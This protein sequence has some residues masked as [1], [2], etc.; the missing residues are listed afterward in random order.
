MRFIALCSVAFLSA[1]TFAGAPATALAAAPATAPANAPAS[2]APP[3][4]YYAQPALHGDTL[5]FQSGGDLW[6]TTVPADGQQAH[7]QRLTSAPGLEARPMISPDGT[8]V[9]Y[10]GAFD[11]NTEVFTLPVSGGSPRRLTFHP[12][13]DIPVA[14]TPDGTQLLIRSDRQ[15]PQGNPEFFLVPAAGGTARR[16]PFGEGGLGSFNAQG[17]LAFNPHSNESWYWKGYRGGTAPDIWVTDKDFKNYRQVTKTDENE[18]FPMW[19]QGRIWFLSDTDGRMNLWSC[20]PD[21]SDRTQHTHAGAADFDL[22]WPSADSSGAPR[23]AFAQGADLWLYD[24]AKN[25]ARK[26]DITL[27]GDRLDD[28]VRLEPVAETM[29]E[30]ALSPDGKRLAVVSRGEVLVGPVGKPKVGV[31][32]AWMQLPGMSSSREG[33]VV[34]TSDDDLLLVSD[35]GGEASI[36]SYDADGAAEGDPETLETLLKADRWI[37]APQAS[38]DGRYVV[39]G[40]KSLRFLLRDTQA[41]K[42]TVIGTSPAGE[43]VDYRFSPDGKWVAWVATLDNGFGQIHLYE[44]AS[45]KDTTVSDGMS[46]DRFPRWDPKG[47]YLYFAS[48]REINPRLDQFDMSFATIQAWSFFAVPLK[49]TT[50]PPLQPAAAQAGVDLKKWGEAPPP[51]GDAEEGDETDAKDAAAGKD[52]T[53]GKS[54]AAG[55]GE[56]AG[57]DAAGGKG[58]AAARRLQRAR[59]EQTARPGRLRSQRA[60]LLVQRQSRW[61]ST[62]SWRGQRI[63]R[64][65]QVSSATWTLSTAGW[66]ICGIQSRAWWT[67]SGRRHPWV[68]RALCWSI[69]TWWRARPSRSRK[70]R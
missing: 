18:L 27:Q 20:K 32:Q 33:G 12:G 41:Q 9:A 19:V 58:R 46:D 49:A 52:A 57:K 25:T 37:F 55:K 31:P 2:A 40:D 22:R 67:R 60:H 14:W 63:C 38:P 48:A 24:A 43:V 21:G 59:A 39:Y 7:A 66:C 13:R 68:R 1:T 62:G 23:I 16:L 5:I 42:D 26:L 47:E 3:R 56:A 51:A 70:P 8:T 50:P 35:R 54:A 6:I 64:S 15:S 36:V 17:D 28:R 44:L 34:W 4:G 61:I 30:L 65:R 10:L 45:G 53:A 29:T 11:G 69:W